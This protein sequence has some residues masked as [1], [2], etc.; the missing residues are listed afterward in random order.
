MRITAD[1]NLLVRLAVGDDPHQS[2][3]AS[4]ALHNAELIAVPTPALCEFVWVLRQTYGFKRSEV[5]SALRQ[6]LSVASV[7]TDRAAAEAG[8]AALE[9]GGDFADACI[10]SEGRR[11]GGA[12]FTT[13]DRRAAALVK[14]TGGE[15]HLLTT[16]GQGHQ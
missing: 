13:F 9:A 3:A 7:R 5:V 4:T 1:T 12:V 10:A 8:I 15:A 14:A 16:S 6:L 11:L 2:R